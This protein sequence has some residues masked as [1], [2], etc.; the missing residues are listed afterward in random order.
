[1]QSYWLRILLSAFV[2]Y[3]C[4]FPEV[5]FAEDCNIGSLNTVQRSECES[6]NDTEASERLDI[7]FNRLLKAA[8]AMRE[9]HKVDFAPDI[10]K[11][12]QLWDAWVNAQCSLEADA[13]MG[14][15]G[16]F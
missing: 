8:S 5:V 3:F 6:R 15:A 13:L 10:E 11:T 9:Q 14:S 1:M 4:T 16:A 12:Q 2:A 7:S